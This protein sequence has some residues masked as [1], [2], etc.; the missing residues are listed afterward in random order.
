MKAKLTLAGA[1]V[2]ALFAMPFAGRAGDLS[3]PPYQPPPEPIAPLFTWS[4]FYLGVNG[5]YLWGSAQWTGGAGNFENSPGGFLGGG[6]LGYNIQTGNFVWGIEGDVDYV[7]AKDTANTAI[8][9]G[10]TFKDTWLATVRGR[11]GYSFNQWLPY[12][13][14]G[15]AWGDAYI[16]SPAGSVSDTKGGW[17]A[18]GGIEYAFGHWS[19]K[20]EYLYAD[21]G[22]TT[23]ATAMCLLPADT[24]LH[25]TSNILRGGM[26][27][28]F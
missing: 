28:R 1:V 7:N 10:C 15:G 19:A 14:G 18:G 21:L 6:T 11:L 8:C 23:C 27:Y 22:D 17:T 2:A 25:F 26:N 3:P 24:T 9:N 12:V 20:V 5:G 16:S 13:T 4:G